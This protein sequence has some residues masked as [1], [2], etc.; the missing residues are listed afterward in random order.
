[1]VLQFDLSGLQIENP[2]AM[3]AKITGYH[4]VTKCSLF[5]SEKVG[6]LFKV[7]ETSGNSRKLHKITSKFGLKSFNIEKE[8]LRTRS[9]I[10]LSYLSRN[11]FLSSKDLPLYKQIDPSQLREVWAISTVFVCS[12]NNCLNRA[13]LLIETNFS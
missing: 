8:T 12:N 5:Y 9:D 11:E 13:S 6:A 4:L 2:F 3:F 7:V 10:F 1:M